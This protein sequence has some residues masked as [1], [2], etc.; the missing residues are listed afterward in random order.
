LTIK[1][2][3]KI[4]LIFAISLLSVGLTAQK[5]AND[6]LNLGIG[7]RAY[8][9]GNAVVA[10]NNGTAAGFYNPAG[11]MYLDGKAQASIMH[12]ELYAGIAK[13]DFASYSFPIS[14]GDRYLGFSL[15][16]TGV[17]DIPNTLFLFDPNGNIQPDNISF[18]SAADYALFFS[19]AQGLHKVLDGLTVGASAK[20]VY[21]SVGK[22][23]TAYGFGIDLGAVYKKPRLTL[24]LHLKDIT[25]TFSAWS[26]DFTPEE[27]DIL[28]LTGN[29]IPESSTEFAFPKIIFGANYALIQKENLTLNG[30][31][32]IDINTDG[33][34]NV[35]LAYADPHLGFEAI[36]NKMN[37]VRAGVNNLQFA[38]NALGEEA[39]LLQPSGGVGIKVADLQIDY[40]LS[41]FGDSENSIFSHI[42]SLAFDIN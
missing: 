13:H 18:F 32:N 6:F 28:A 34:R 2:M 19:Y 16:R 3:N 37:F 30:E 22:F 42:V 38:S 5:F 12:A 35:L 33:Q 1:N 7:A 39:L 11:L 15:I 21:R 24:G 20:V 41:H 36:F 31:V 10:S 27:K 9:M 23:S 8:A 17:D 4:F 40:A 26:F 14:D 29:L 25:T